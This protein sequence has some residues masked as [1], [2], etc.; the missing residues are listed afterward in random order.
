MNPFTFK[1][2]DLLYRTDYLEIFSDGFTK[3][4]RIDSTYTLG[5]CLQPN[6]VERVP[7]EGVEG[8]V[9]LVKMTHLIKLPE[10]IMEEFLAKLKAQ[11]EAFEAAT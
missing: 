3:L 7:V 9:A 4:K 11:Y 5:L 2:L 1:T 6:T 8:V 10:V